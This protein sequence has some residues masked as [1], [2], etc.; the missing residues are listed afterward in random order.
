[1]RLL[2]LA[3]LALLPGPAPTATVSGKIGFGAGGAKPVPSFVYTGRDRRLLAK[4]PPESPVAVWLEGG[5]AKASGEGSTVDV[6]QKG[7]HYVPRVLV[8]AV[9]TSVRFPNEDDTLHNVF[10]LSPGN[11]F[12]LG[13]WGKGKANQWTMSEKGRVDVRCKVH[14]HM[15]A[16][17]HVVDSPH[18]TVAAADGTFALQGVPPGSYTLVAWKEEH[19]FLRQAVEVKAD[20]AKV[21]AQFARAAPAPARETA[22]GGCS[23]R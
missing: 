23:T 21:E 19:G 10:S 6:Q 15:K 17:I 11:T 5:A 8:V 7:L 1:M 16:F 4:E 14:D 22:C 20:G 9:G 13:K 3:A 12:D 2:V 18:R